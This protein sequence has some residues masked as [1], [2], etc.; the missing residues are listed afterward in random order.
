VLD[1]FLGA[2][3]SGRRNHLHGLGDLLRRFDRAD[4]APNVQE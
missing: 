2:A 4:A 3:Q 1:P